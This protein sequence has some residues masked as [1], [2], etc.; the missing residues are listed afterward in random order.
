MKLFDLHCDTLTELYDKQECLSANSCHISLSR[1]TRYAA[2]RQVF[3]V[4]SHHDLSDD[5][6]FERFFR[7]TDYAAPMLRD[8]AAAHA[9]IPY[10]GVEGGALLGGKIAR[11]DR[12]FRAGVRI[13]TLTWAGE[14]CIGGA[15]GTN[16]GL[17]AFGYAVLARCLTLGILPDVSHASDTMFWQTLSFVRQ[18]GGALI[19]SHSDCRALCDHP[20][21]LTDS[22]LR[23][24]FAADSLCGLNLCPAFLSSDHA[25]AEAA[26]SHVLHMLELGGEG[27][28]CLGCD[29]DGTSLPEGFAGIDDLYR[30]ADRLAAHSLTDAQIEAIFFGNA[31]SFFDRH[32]ITPVC[33]S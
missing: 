25:D 31:A 15:H 4:W 23:A 22:M 5:E 18:N 27:H 13:L 32:G 12:L 17:T 20:R 28:V 7:V 1:I 6:N 11:L 8:A 10:L 29:L 16:S 2:W 3:A 33:G 30:I 24:L 9:V 19:A 21:N 14:N 26:A